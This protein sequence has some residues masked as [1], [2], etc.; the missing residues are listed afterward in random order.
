MLALFFP[1]IRGVHHSSLCAWQSLHSPRFSFAT[2]EPREREWLCPLKCGFF[3]LSPS[4]S[5][6]IRLT[7]RGLTDPGWRTLSFGQVLVKG[8]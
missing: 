6:E 4:S 5:E 7:D 3:D 2:A 1:G 8:V